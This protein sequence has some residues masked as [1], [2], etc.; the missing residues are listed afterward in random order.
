MASTILLL[1]AVFALPAL[2][3]PVTTYQLGRRLGRPAVT[4]W[5][6]ICFMPLV[7]AIILAARLV[8]TNETHSDIQGNVFA[9]LVA[10]SFPALACIPGL[11]MLKRAKRP[12]PEDRIQLG[13]SPDTSQQVP[14]KTNEILPNRIEG[15]R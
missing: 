12:A 5:V 15:G 8:S 13:F 6:G 9:L 11:T 3:C 2:V 1:L 10:G 4:I 7:P 14:I